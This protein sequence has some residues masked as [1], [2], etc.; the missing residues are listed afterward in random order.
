MNLQFWKGKKV[1]GMGVNSEDMLEFFFE[2]DLI[3]F[4][5]PP[6]IFVL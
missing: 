1:K 6:P 2:T 4:L 3:F 5:P